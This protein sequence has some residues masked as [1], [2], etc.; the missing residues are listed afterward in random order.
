MLLKPQQAAS[1]GSL[2]QGGTSMIELTEAP[3]AVRNQQ[4]STKPKATPTEP[5]RLPLYAVVL[6][7]DDFHSVDYAVEA[8]QKVFGYDWLN[9]P[10]LIRKGERHGRAHVWTGPLETA[11]FKRDRLQEVGPDVWAKN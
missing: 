1:A 5:R 4:T 11:E 9:S 10:A 7:D 8:L 2:E 3:S 6:H